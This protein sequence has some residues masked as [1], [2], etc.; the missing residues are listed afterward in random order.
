MKSTKNALGITFAVQFDNHWKLFDISTAETDTSDKFPL[1]ESG[2]IDFDLKLK[3]DDDI[4][5]SEFFIQLCWTCSNVF[6]KSYYPL[7]GTFS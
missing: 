5:L 2:R 6:F 3:L 7:T 4:S 1:I